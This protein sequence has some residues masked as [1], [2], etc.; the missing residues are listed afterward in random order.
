MIPNINST[1][2][3]MPCPA[4]GS[5]TFCVIAVA[6]AKEDN[7]INAGSS[8]AAVRIAPTKPPTTKA[9]HGTTG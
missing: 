7:R 6:P 9:I 3:R 5:G 2:N 4:G 1:V 8:S